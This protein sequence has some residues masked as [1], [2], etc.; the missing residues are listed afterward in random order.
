MA[1]E[2]LYLAFRRFSQRVVRVNHNSE[3]ERSELFNRLSVRLKAHPLYRAYIDYIT[4]NFKTFSEKVKTQYKG[5]IAQKIRR[6]IEYENTHGHKSLIRFLQSLRNA[7]WS[8]KG[9]QLSA[10]FAASLFSWKEENVTDQ[11]ISRAIDD[12]SE[13][14]DMGRHHQLEGAHP[15]GC[16]KDWTLIVNE[17]SLKIW[18]RP[19]PNS[20]LYEYKVYGRYDDVSPSAF[21]QVQIDLEYR[22]KW[23]HYV[24]KLEVIDKDPGS[25]SE[26]VQWVTNYPA[27]WYSREFLYIRRFK[28]DKERNVM[29]YV[30]RAVD[31]PECPKKNDFV[32]VDPYSSYMVIKPNT[33]FEENGLEYVMTYHDDPQLMY[34]SLAFSFA[35][36]IGIEFVDKMHKAA[37]ELQKRS[38]FRPSYVPSSD[39]SVSATSSGNYIPNYQ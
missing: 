19:L 16:L 15:T 6:T 1:P 29:A 21:Y 25:K 24:V 3:R 30:A 11:E 33:T 28:I 12:M 35:T 36:S 10:L 32:R 5:V 20:H 23:D 37:K 4:E 8:R 22:K 7:F 38:G 9:P 14:Q 34:S 2:G 31:H 27:T 26:V 17:P 18:R 39:S 13:I